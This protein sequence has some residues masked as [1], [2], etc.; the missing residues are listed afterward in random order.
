MDSKR[1][2]GHEISGPIIV[3]KIILYS[4]IRCKINS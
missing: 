4:I 2:D 3:Q 1:N